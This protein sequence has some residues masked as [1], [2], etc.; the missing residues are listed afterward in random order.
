[1]R[2]ARLVP[3]LIIPVLMAA[4]IA[5]AQDLQTNQAAPTFDQQKY[6]ALAA[7][8]LHEIG[9]HQ[10]LSE[11]VEQRR[12]AFGGALP[13]PSEDVAHFA[14]K[15]IGQRY[16]RK[17]YDRD[18]GQADC[19]TFTERCIALG[20]TSSWQAADK[21]QNR[22]RWQNGSGAKA[23]L[24]REPLFDWIPANA[25][26]FDDVTQHLGAPV[27]AFEAVFE[28]R[29]M[30][31]QYVA[32]VDM[33]TAYPALRT[34]D[35]LFVIAETSN[36]PSD[37]VLRTRCVHMAITLQP[38]K[39]EP[40]QML[41]S[42]PP[43]ACQW[44]LDNFLKNRNVR[45][46]KVLRLKPNA[47]QIVAGDFAKRNVL[48]NSSPAAIDNRLR[49]SKGEFGFVTPTRTADSTMELEGVVY[50]VVQIRE[51]ETLWSLF[52]SGWKAVCNL[53]VNKSF[54]QRHPSLDANGYRGDTIY[55]PL[56]W[57]SGEITPP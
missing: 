3:R 29:T 49:L 20:C 44:P 38:G 31:A 50:G 27:T 21:L 14:L 37:P 56:R 16:Q 33:P 13:D 54:V 43:A 42:Y 28:G 30:T 57:S 23:D 46:L 17:A 22:L 12:L 19:V 52:K 8:R 48:L 41:H 53:P 7:K 6:A 36:P 51:G 2:T 40:V 55:V 5:S 10:Q 1:M 35:I 11:Y 15:S 4:P 24:N 9:G 26:L 47:R 18:L 34:G 25:W 32:N 45:G 39:D